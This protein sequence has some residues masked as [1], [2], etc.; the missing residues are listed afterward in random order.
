M[1]CSRKIAFECLYRNK[2]DQW[3]LQLALK[4]AR[5]DSRAPRNRP[6]AQGFQQGLRLDPY[7]LELGARLGIIHDARTHVEH[8]N[9]ILQDTAG[10]A[11]RPRRA[12]P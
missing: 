7:L 2:L 8:C 9:V 10:R 12:F 6:H 3:V 1:N 11:T 5:L 4:C